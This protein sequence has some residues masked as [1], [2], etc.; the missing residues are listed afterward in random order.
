MEIE[1]QAYKYFDG[2]NYESEDCGGL[3]ILYI[4]EGKD[5]EGEVEDGGCT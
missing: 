5:R 1:G 2:E 3:N 4:E